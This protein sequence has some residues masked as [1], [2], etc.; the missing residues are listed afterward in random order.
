MN[1]SHYSDIKINFSFRK[2][3]NERFQ[4]KPIKPGFSNS[5]FHSSFVVTS[6]WKW[7]WAPFFAAIFRTVAKFYARKKKKTQNCKFDTGIFLTICVQNCFTSFGFDLFRDCI[8]EKF[9]FILKFCL[10]SLRFLSRY[11]Q[12]KILRINGYIESKK[13]ANMSLFCRRTLDG[14]FMSRILA[15][16]LLLSAER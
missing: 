8:F 1:I 11:L 7:T 5:L 14:K 15:Y 2:T 6:I 3:T 13:W 9:R 4:N 16:V 12:I 10:I